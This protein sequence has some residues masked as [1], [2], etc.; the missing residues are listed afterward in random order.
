MAVQTPYSHHK[1]DSSDTFPGRL[2]TRRKPSPESIAFHVSQHG[3][4]ATADQV[5]MWMFETSD[6]RARL[7][8]DLQGLIDI[9][10]ELAIAYLKSLGK[11]P[12]QEPCDRLTVTDIHQAVEDVADKKMPLPP[13]QEWVDTV[14]KMYTR[15]YFAASALPKIARS[16]AVHYLRSIKST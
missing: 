8:Y 9:E 15:Q 16:A 10:P 3:H 6:D 13:L 7:T 11:S 1:G 14:G 5:A 2:K 4:N 12:K